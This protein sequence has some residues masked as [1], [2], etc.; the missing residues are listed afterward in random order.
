VKIKTFLT[1]ILNLFLIAGLLAGLLLSARTPTPV[2]ATHND[3]DPGFDSSTGANG[4]VRSLAVQSD[5]KVLIGGLFTT[6]NGIARNHIARLNTDGSLDTTFDPGSGTSGQNGNVMAIAVQ[7]DGQILIGGAFYTYNGVARGGIAR[8]NA[9][10]SLD[11]SFDPGTGLGSGNPYPM[12]IVV[13]SDGKIFI[14]GWFASYNGVARSCIVRLNADGSLDTTFD[15]STGANAHVNAIVVKSDGQILIGGWF[16]TYNGVALGRIARL[17][18]DGSLDTTFN[19]GT[20]ANNTIYAMAVQSDGQILIGGTFTTYNG[21]GRSRFTRLNAD[22][23]LDTTFLNTGVGGTV[24]S[25]IV[26]NDGKILISNGIVRFN[27][28]GS[29]DT[30]F[31]SGGANSTV[32]AIAVQSNGQ[33]FI[34]GDFTTYGA[35]ARNHI[36]RLGGPDIALSSPAVEAANIL[37]GATDLVVYRLNVAVTNQWAAGAT[38]TSLTVTPGGTYLPADLTANSFKLRYSADATLDAGDATLSTRAIVAS[39]SPLAFTGLSQTI[40]KDSTGYL[41][42]TVDVALSITDNRTLSI[43]AP[44]LSNVIFS[45]G[46][47]SGVLTAGGTQTFI[48]SIYADPA[49]ICYGNIFCYTSLQ[50]AVE[51]AG[52]NCLVT[53]YGGTYAESV[54]LNKNTHVRL[55][56]DATITGNLTLV[57]GAFHLLNNTLTLGGDFTNITTFDAGTGTV[58][59]NGSALQTI[60]GAGVTTFNHLTIVNTSGL[61]PAVKLKTDAVVNGTLTL[62]EGVLGVYAETFT[63]NGPVNTTGGSTA[64]LLSTTTYAQAAP[65]QNVAPG[66]YGHLAFNDQPKTLPGSGVVSI[67]GDFDPG[68]ASGHTV[69]GST[70]AFN[71]SGTQTI[72]HDVALNDVSVASGVTLTTA[73]NVTVGGA[74]TNNGWTKETKAVV[75]GASALPFGLADVVVDVTT[76]GSLASLEV[77]R[78]DQSHPNATGVLQTGKWWQITPTGGGYTATL[79]L[80]T[81]FV[82]DDKDKVCRYTGADQ[83]WDCAMSSFDAALHTITRA[84]VT[85]FSEWAAGNDSGPTAVE[86]RLLKAQSPG[87]GW[88]ALIG[89]AG[90][91]LMIGMGWL[92][93]SRKRP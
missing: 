32:Y 37:A 23:S 66:Q 13:Q 20:G 53:V 62:Q 91:T 18:A 55:V 84:G 41:F 8:L 58:V 9:D 45:G 2:Y 67:K 70:V 10:G 72:A 75:D 30:T 89:L 51:A 79:T 60:G 49:G 44:A 40:A 3:V 69:T 5:G 19:P 54:T 78:R 71:G 86:V 57:V 64:R 36:A 6:Y 82:P 38:L 76:R 1:R 85:A 28:D 83:V 31:G 87:V 93:M 4:L 42:V 90:L 46:S 17:N 34:C 7:S 29:P 21:V 26:Q 24:Y 35:V 39:G 12:T 22:G 27:T 15:S 68:A 63:L 47:K 77:I 33:I 11:T 59:L 16:T 52:P 81:N 65:G 73:A 80:P 56:E 50:A 88:G 48:T 14:G 25:I 43:G 74:L 61:S 92:L